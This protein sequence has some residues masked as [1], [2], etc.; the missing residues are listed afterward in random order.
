MV[1]SGSF[2]TDDSSSVIRYINRHVGEA[3]ELGCCQITRAAFDTVKQ[4]GESFERL[5]TD[6]NFCEQIA[7]RY[8]IYLHHRFGTWDRAVQSYNAGRPCRAGRRYLARIKRLFQYPES[9]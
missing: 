8:L 4:T 3:G 1:E 7:A 6:T 2:Y 5:S 9:P